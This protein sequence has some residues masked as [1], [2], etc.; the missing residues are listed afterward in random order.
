[1]LPADQPMIGPDVDKQ[2]D[3]RERR[4]QLFITKVFCP[5]GGSIAA[6]IG[7]PMKESSSERHIYYVSVYYVC[8]L[9]RTTVALLTTDQYS[10]TQNVKFR[11]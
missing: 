3:T 4:T 6:V 11:V 1:M 10:L 7:S 2:Q 5:A 9:S 8:A